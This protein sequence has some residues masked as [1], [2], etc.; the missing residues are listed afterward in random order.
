M[1]FLASCSKSTEPTDSMNMSEYYPTSIG[2]W[3]KY[4]TWSLDSNGTRIEITSRDSIVSSGTI[5]LK[6]KN[7]PLFLAW[8]LDYIGKSDTTEYYYA[9]GSIL[10][11]YMPATMSSFLKP[12]RDTSS[13]KWGLFADMNGTNWTIINDSLSKDTLGY[14]VK[15]TLKMTG[16]K[17]TQKN[18]SIKGK[19]IQSQ[20]FIYNFKLKTTAYLL[21]Q[22]FSSFDNEM[23]IEFWYGKG[24]GLVNQITRIIKDE[25]MNL[26]V[27][28][29]TILID[30]NIK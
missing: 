30:Y 27:N 10:Y 13:W 17:G 20:Q 25:G 24:V 29:E 14:T 2:S 5:T 26:G 21:G 3:W 12:G 8:N 28:R 7:V 11:A 4:D 22:V 19:T 23:Q 6:G 1:V 15:Q 18:Y 16:T 9:E